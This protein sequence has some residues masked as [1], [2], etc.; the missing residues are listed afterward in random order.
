[1]I[2]L[3]FWNIRGVTRAPNLRRLRKLIKVYDLQLV[4]VVEPK[5][6]VESIT[7]IRIKLGMDCCMF[8]HWGSVWL[9]YGRCLRVRLLG[10][11]PNI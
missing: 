4:I 6:R 7:D 5:L 9:F 11:L 8:N 3:L 2:K 1:M 10:S